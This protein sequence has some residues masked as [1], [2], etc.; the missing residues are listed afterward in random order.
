MKTY[1]STWTLDGGVVS[2][3]PWPLYPRRKCLQYPLNRR[4]GGPQSRLERRGEEKN[5][6]P[7]PGIKPRAVQFV[8]R[9]YPDKNVLITNDYCFVPFT[10]LALKWMLHYYKAY[11]STTL[12]EAECHHFLSGVYFHSPSQ[13]SNS[14]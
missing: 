11:R 1:G 10:V 12:H 9:H 3:T 5:L 6:L 13:F 7:L 14:L 4:L 8:A 2:F